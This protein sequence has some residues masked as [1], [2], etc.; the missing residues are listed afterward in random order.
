[1]TRVRAAAVAVEARAARAERKARESAALLA[2]AHGEVDEVA[3]KV[4]LLESE[5]VVVRQAQN[6]AEVKLPDLV[7]RATD[8]N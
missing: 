4:M 6:M 5:L 3:Q 1:V 2:S 8:A 7:D